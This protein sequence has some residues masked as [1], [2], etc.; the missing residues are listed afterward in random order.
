MNR[1]SETNGHHN[2]YHIG[3]NRNSRY[4]GEREEAKTENHEN[5]QEKTKSSNIRFPQ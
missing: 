5:K 4:R 3:L 1:N 2:V